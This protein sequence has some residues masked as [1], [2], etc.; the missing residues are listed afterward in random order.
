MTSLRELQVDFSAS[1]FGEAAA[2]HAAAFAGQIENHAFPGERLLQVYRNNILSSL[3]G[4]LED[5]YPVIQRLVGEGFF[6]YAAHELMVRHPPHSGNLHDFGEQF[7]AFL[8]EFEP[9]MGLVYLPD[10]GRLEWAWHRAFHS[11]D[12]GPLDPAKLA[13][14]PAEC[15]ERIVFRLHPSA[16]LVSS[17]FPVLQIW[18]VNQDEAESSDQETDPG[19]V[20]LESG[21][22]QVLV[23]RSE[24]RVRMY[25]LSP[26]EYT[27]LAALESRRTFGEACE[28]SL[29]TEPHLDVPTVLRR[30]VTQATLVDVEY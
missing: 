11:A 6:N 13:S 7:P 30:H 8:A 22:E 24:L 9:A 15:H 17:S 19:T 29:D 14:I 4:A 27:L 2:E 5:V 12:H 10:V 21:G 1:V 18:E 20:D 16:R 3:T 28:A 26:G 25:R 23:L